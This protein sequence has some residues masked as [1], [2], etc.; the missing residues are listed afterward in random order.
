MSTYQ[1]PEEDGSSSEEE[2]TP[3][4]SHYSSDISSAHTPNEATHSNP[5]ATDSE[6]E[7]ENDSDG[8]SGDEYENKSSHGP[9][10]SISDSQDEEED[11]TPGHAKTTDSGD[12]DATDVSSD[13]NNMPARTKKRQELYCEFTWAELSHSIDP[14]LPIPKPDGTGGCDYSIKEMI[15]LGSN[16]QDDADTYKDILRS[17]RSHCRKNLDLSLPMRKQVKAK[18]VLVELKVCEDFPLLRNFAGG[19]PVHALIQQYLKN[20]TEQARKSALRQAT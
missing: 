7:E 20:T 5:E 18:T 14:I 4:P 11:I 3:P 9:I 12:V 10:A 19:W 13:D 15:G 2:L 6:S 1:E 16:H 17:V 8:L